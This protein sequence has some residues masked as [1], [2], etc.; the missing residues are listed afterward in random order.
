VFFASFQLLTRTFYSMQDSRTPALVNVASAIV[1]IGLDVLYV[2][3]LGLGVQGLALGHASSYAFSTTVAVVLLRRRLRG[4]DGA[5]IARSLVGIA[6]GALAA[7]GAA[8]GVWRGL[9]SIAGSGSIGALLLEVV[10][11]VVAGV[12]AFLTAALMVRIEEVDE[13]RRQLRA[14]WR[15]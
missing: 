14:R 1:N 9:A 6:L 7:G 8:W 12:L 13:L 2:N 11:A 15:R 10:A 5:R 3:A 4:I